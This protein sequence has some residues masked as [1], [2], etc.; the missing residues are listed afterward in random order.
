MT[1]IDASTLYG[2]LNLLLLQALEHEPGHGLEIQRR[3]ERLSEAALNVEEGAL[4]PGLRRLERDGLV[5][6]EWGISDA[7]RRARFYQITR[8]GRARLARE[9]ASWLDTVRAVG[10]V[11]RIR[12][13]G[14]G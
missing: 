7:R 1:D 12:P 4:Y 13:E 11:L 14:V 5:T 10:R 9:R 6:S 3:I 2:T 8:K